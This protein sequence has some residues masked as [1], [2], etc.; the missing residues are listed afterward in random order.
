MKQWKMLGDFVA[1]PSCSS[2]KTICGRIHKT[3]FDQTN[4]AAILRKETSWRRRWKPDIN[5]QAWRPFIISG[6]L[7]L[8]KTMFVETECC[9][10]FCLWDFSTMW[11]EKVEQ[12]NFRIRAKVWNCVFWCHF[13]DSMCLYVIGVNGCQHYIWFCPRSMIFV[14]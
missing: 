14:K 5:S 10:E 11:Y 2:A 3:G 9:Y 4:M 12:D 1:A 6:K 8:V 7:F 13:L